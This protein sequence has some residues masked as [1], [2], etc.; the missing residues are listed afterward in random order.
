MPNKNSVERYV[1]RF[2]GEGAKPAVDVKRI[3]DSGNITVLDNSSPRML[4]VEADQGRLKALVDTMPGWI[5]TPEQVIPL[6][7]TRAKVKRGPG[8]KR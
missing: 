4:L 6:P 7:D 1:L 3:L 5:M 8:K 2:R